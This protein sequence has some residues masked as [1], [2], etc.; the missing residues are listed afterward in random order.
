[1]N[2]S[3]V[4]NDSDDVREKLTVIDGGKALTPLRYVD[5]SKWGDEPAP[6]RVWA[7][8]NRIP[9]CQPHLTTGHGA[10]GKSLLEMQRA[11]AHC[12]GQPWLGM[13]VRPGPVM[14]LSCEE[15]QDE[16]WRRLEA[17]LKHCD[18]RFKDITGQLHLLA[19]AND[20]CLLAV[21][22]RRGI[23]TPTEL[24]DRLLADAMRIRPVA[25]IIDTLTDVYAGDEIDR[26]QT[27][28]F[29]K[30]LQRMSMTART[31]VGLVAHPSLSGLQ[32]GSGLSGSTG[33]HNKMRSRLY[34]RAP[35]TAA[36]EPIDSD[37][38]ELKFLKNNYGKQGDAV[39]IRWQEGV[40]VREP[41]EGSVEYAQRDASD[42]TQFVCMLNA[43]IKENRSPMSDK[44]KAHNYAPN[45]LAERRPDLGPKRIEAAMNRLLAKNK[46]HLEPYG[47]LRKGWTRLALGPRPEE[48]QP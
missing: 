35:E 7:V 20:D 21:P 26:S 33:W 24:Y 14:Y 32:S 42:E 30:L 23:I 37:L 39:Q 5:M 27:T 3:Y 43:H 34:M 10:I 13:K 41:G 48:P 40:F 31:S 9:M 16:L 25:I 11:V 44:K 38:R 46:I 8:E 36:G 4:P 18:A 12:L 2:T 45:V 22:E 17:I 28:Q 6:A 29:V 19:Y 15:E 1:M 47:E